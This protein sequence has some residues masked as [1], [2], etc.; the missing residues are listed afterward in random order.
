MATC[1]VILLG[2]LFAALL[3]AA[4]PSLLDLALPGTRVAI[5][6]NIR[7]L[8]GSEFARS[9]AQQAPPMGTDW[10]AMLSASGLDIFRDVEEILIMSTAA[11]ENA[12]V[13]IAARGSFDLQ[14]LPASVPRFQGIPLLG[15]TR[16]SPGAVA[17]LDSA[18]AL[19]GDL[20]L[21]KAAIQRRGRPASV[22]PDLAA[23]IRTLSGNYDIWAAGQVPAGAMA[24]EMPAEVPAAF[25]SVDMFR[26]GA[27]FAHGLDFAMQLRAGTE[28]DAQGMATAVGILLEFARQK[29]PAAAKLPA[30]EL[31]VEGRTLYASLRIPQAQV[32]QAMLARA[33]T[34][35]ARPAPA[36][37]PETPSKY[38]P[39]TDLVIIASPSD[40][41]IRVFGSKP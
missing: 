35:P 12:P 40:G 13:L 7:N 8:A 2:G 28:K 22:D 5:G 25:K 1:R 34:G 32:E 23:A 36:P 14:A 37:K 24:R 38:P 18:T 31:R 26:L 19:A 11:P 10:R 29:D 21:L 15:G 33:G 16:K 3:G 20:P 41:G 17:I 30:P 9:L 39:G 27:T 6:I 4:E